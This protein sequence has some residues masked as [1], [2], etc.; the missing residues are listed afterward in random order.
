MNVLLS[1]RLAYCAC[2]YLLDIFEYA[3]WMEDEKESN[4]F[5]AWDEQWSAVE[6][7][8]LFWVRN[9]RHEVLKT[10]QLNWESREYLRTITNKHL[11]DLGY[12]WVERWATAAQL[13]AA[14]V[15]EFSEN[16]WIY[17]VYA[18]WQQHCL[19]AFDTLFTQPPLSVSPSHPRYQIQATH[20]RHLMALRGLER[21]RLADLPTASHA[22]L[23]QAQAG[24][25]DLAVTLA[26]E[27]RA[28]VESAAKHLPW[29]QLESAPD[30]PD[31]AAPP[32]N[33]DDSIPW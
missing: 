20:V 15:P 27:W 26:H 14:R 23:V 25:E 10:L 32:S 22:A 30:L 28:A 8:I 11:D 9:E 17:F 18:A 13:F 5:F 1:T 16:T 7:N 6:H 24:L 31:L 19:R 29:A 12:R 21:P 2:E 4:E 33:D 3:G